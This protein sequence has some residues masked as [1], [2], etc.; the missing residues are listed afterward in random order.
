[1][2]RR[3]LVDLHIPPAELLR[4]YRGSAS[5]ISAV[6]RHGRRLQFPA[7]ALR[8][9]VTRDGIRGTFVLQAGAGNRLERVQR[10]S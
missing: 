8:P 3:Y 6:D 10:M 5:S 2:V 1:M 7:S 9:F 4:Y